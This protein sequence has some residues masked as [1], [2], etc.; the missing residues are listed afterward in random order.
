M[1]ILSN[2]LLSE[3]CSHANN[4][5]LKQLR[6]VNQTLNHFAAEC[7]FEDIPLILLPDSVDNLRKIIDHPTLRCYVRSITYC[8]ERLDSQW[9]NYERWKLF[10]QHVS[11]DDV[12]PD[13][14]VGW[15]RFCRL[16][17]EQ[18]FL[19]NSGVEFKLF[20]DA[21]TRLPSLTLY[22]SLIRTGSNPMIRL[23]SL[24]TIELPK[25]PSCLSILPLCQRLIKHSRCWKYLHQR[26]F[27]F[28]AHW[29]LVVNV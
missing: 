8:A 2:E 21:L 28:C 11:T 14:K 4:T 13:S 24:F 9:E 26:T 12:S 20:K 29:D 6:L 1:A 27:V 25:R 23:I 16:L 22:P 17:S 3:I 5:T 10:A 7:L 19:V 18:R 15:Y